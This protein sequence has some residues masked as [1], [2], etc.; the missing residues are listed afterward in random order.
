MFQKFIIFILFLG[1]I[2]GG[3]AVAQAEETTPMD[4][5]SPATSEVAIPASALTSLDDLTVV[6]TEPTPLDDP[7]ITPGYFFYP[8]KLFF[9]NIGSTFTFGDLAK[10]KRFSNLAERRMA[11]AKITMEKGQ[12]KN[13]ENALNRYQKLLDNSLEYSQRARVAGKD[14]S[15]IQE[16]MS[17]MTENHLLVLDKVLQQVPQSAK[18]A[19]EKVIQ[20]AKEISS[21]RQMKALDDLGKTN[22]QKAVQLNGEMLQRRAVWMSEKIAANDESG[23]EKKLAEWQKHAD[24][25]KKIREEDKGLASVTAEETE[26][27][28]KDIQAVRDQAETSSAELQGAI[29]NARGKMVNRQLEF[30]ETLKEENPQ[31]AVFLLDKIMKERFAHLTEQ[32][33]L[34]EETAPVTGNS[35]L[36]AVTRLEIKQIGDWIKANGLNQYGDPQGTSY[37][38]GNP[39]FN[40]S[41]GI[42]INTI[43]Y[44]LENYPDRP[45]KGMAEDKKIKENLQEQAAYIGLWQGMAD[46]IE[47]DQGELPVEGIEK[48]K[49]LLYQFS[50]E[51]LKELDILYQK[52]SPENKEA[53]EEMMSIPEGERQR[54]EMTA[55]QLRLEQ[56]QGSE[57]IVPERVR[58]AVQNRLQAEEA[59]RLQAAKKIQEGQQDNPAPSATPPTSVTPPNQGGASHLDSDSNAG[60]GGSNANQGGANKP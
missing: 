55:P 3:A 39:L 46:Q 12:E 20:R 53:V 22:S 2:L 15:A 48:R 52:L 23:A 31:G 24:F 6:S 27:A 5:T 11:E 47:S 58:Q 9:E 56:K 43:D 10:A 29:Q 42:E 26:K 19:I 33:A 16:K 7:G 57:N 13:S 18:P 21:S 28:L 25:L 14:S 36:G 17:Q 35:G 38:G 41:T 60:S 59:T 50:N 45:W 54:I 44:L 34:P 37:T 51:R 4:A 32:L 30:L 1:L 40:E 49:E 8:F